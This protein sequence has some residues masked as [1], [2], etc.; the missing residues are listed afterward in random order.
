MIT[1]TNKP[2]I[3]A[4][5]RFREG[6]RETQRPQSLKSSRRVAAAATFQPAHVWVPACAGMT[7]K[8]SA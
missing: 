3:P 8:E 1:S 7:M 6:R 4:N 2:V 5:P